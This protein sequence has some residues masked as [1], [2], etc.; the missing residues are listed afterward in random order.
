[1]RDEGE[2]RAIDGLL[3]ELAR[4]K[5]DAI[6]RILN[7]TR[8]SRW[9]KALR[10][11][12]ASILLAAAGI[13][14]A[15]PWSGR[16]IVEV[17]SGEVRRE[18][19][20][21]VTDSGRPA[22]LRL[23]G[24]GRV[25]MNGDTALAVRSPENIRLDRGEAEFRVA[26]QGGRPFVV[27][28]EFGEIR[29]PGT[30]FTA[31][32]VRDGEK[33][34]LRV[35]VEEGAVEVVNARGRVRAAA[36]ENVVVF[37][38]R[39]PGKKKRLYLDPIDVEPAR[40]S[41]D[42]E[43]RVDYDIAYV[44]APRKG[45][46]RN[47]VWAEIAHPGYMD[48][49]A[50]LMLL[51][52]D[53]SEEVLVEGGKGSVLDPFV[54]FD[55]EWIYYS[56]IHDLTG[57]GSFAPPKSGA[58]IFRIHVKTRKI[59]R[60]T[61]QEFTPNTGAAPWA[62]GFRSREEGKTWFPYGVLNLGPCPLPGGRV[63]FVSNRDGFRPPKHS[64]PALQL[65]VMD[66]DGKN[67]EK[68]G[69]LNIGMA[70][71]P[72]AL[73]D[74]RVMWSSLESQGVRSSILWGLW[75]IRP[76][77]TQW[78]PIVSAF[79][80][81]GVGAP[82]AFH[83]QTQLSD[84]SLVVEEYYNANNS[85]FG[86]YVK[87]PPGAPRGASAFGPG[88]RGDPRNPALR[89]G[90]HYNGWPKLYRLPFSPY[91]IESLTRFANNGEGS[92]DPSRLGKKDTARVGKVT[93]P[94]GAPDNHLLTVWSPGPVNHQN[95]LK[96]PTPDAGIYLIKSGRPVDEPGQMLLVKNDPKVNEQWPRAVVPYR[97]IYG[98]DEPRRLPALRND[99]S[100][101]RHLPEG[102]PF[103]LVGTSSFYKRESYPNG[104]VPVGSVTASF[105]GG[106][107]HN[108][109]RDLDPFNTSENGKFVNWM[110][111]GAD[112]GRYDNADIH[113]V[114]ILA[115]EPTTDRPRG[116]KHGR[117]FWSH[118]MER[119]RILGELP[120]RKFPDGRQPVD[121]D[122][123]PDTS[124]L[125]KIPADTAF[126]FQTLDKDGMVL[127]MAQTWHQVRPGEMRVDCGGCH[128]HSQKP[129]LFEDSAA[130]KPEYEIFDLTKRAP[131]LTTKERDESGRQWDARRETGLRFADAPVKSVEYFRDV[132]PILDRSCVACHTKKSKKPAGNLVL[133]ADD[134]K[135]RIGHGPE[136][137]G[138][139]TRLAADQKA[140]FGHKPVNN[141][142]G[143]TTWRHLQAS[144]YVRKL[145]SRRSLLVW[146]IYGRRTDGWSNDDFP[147]ETVPGDPSTLELRGE[148]VPVTA[149]TLNTADLD[150]TGSVM[151]PPEAV[152]GTYEAP[153][154]GTIKVEPLTDEDRKTIVRWI[155][156]GCPI[157]L[158]FDPAN[159]SARGF[160]WMLDDNRPILTLT[161]PLAG[162]NPPV[163]RFVVGMHDY[164]TGLAPASFRVVADFEVDGRPAG[165]NLAPLF[166]PAGDGVRVLKLET[167]VRRLG[168]GVL[169]VS[170]RDREGNLTRIER[171]FSV[172]P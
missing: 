13:L 117:R 61:R 165:E 85:G 151:P 14:F 140:Q 84:G 18:E 121:P 37:Q 114:R 42:P 136:L 3:R 124:F 128:A 7:R 112:A 25:F 32:V 101:S 93:H 63:M 143:A 28:T 44:R 31:A 34:S 122:G 90:R 70:L 119:L 137:P 99:G 148:P 102:T 145:Q 17:V 100:I 66:D 147:T 130:S 131:L 104:V 54:S 110:N 40:L 76:D 141:R 1:M 142:Y 129:T 152:A 155:D 6:R 170:V 69:H 106:R 138:T 47:S 169:T 120:L 135:I 157:D 162:E 86:A 146:K 89:F 150:Y 39:A 167:P 10:V 20:R 67:V 38:D 127:N 11:L 74:G 45:D 111:Q 113:A 139:Y 57:A 163:D 26:R 36:G 5:D 171:T 125:A 92:A 132:R 126:T 88:Y 96:T 166:A 160:G 22:E 105:A 108:G 51:H 24:G 65:F 56:K 15:R 77:G 158:D 95:G 19:G 168:K 71:H 58:D 81:S 8:P 87:L 48:A 60:L 4:E 2:L 134:E 118:A 33:A 83:F 75:S 29:V 41:S 43:V 79:D 49:G 97:R 161:Y 154:G 149:R 78:G 172:R 30:R 159:P 94:S 52:P 156:L 16:S 59:V 46:R 164:Y 116:A 9:G 68:I 21:L 12:A 72:V 107:D 27:S 23:A 82:N 144:R 80:T 103:G 73:K 50:D 98:V 35:T 109:Y 91:G 53:G 62:K 64:W 153:D 115:M 133:D 123:N 55:G